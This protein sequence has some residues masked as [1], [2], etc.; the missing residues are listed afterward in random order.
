LGHL[1]RYYGLYSSRSKGKA[2]QE[3]SVAKFGYRPKITC[4]VK[5]E[6]SLGD[7]AEEVS[8]KARRKSR[9]RLIQKVYEV[10]PLACPRYSHKMPKVL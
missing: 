4:N 2:N 9:A 6:H 5:P 10:D 8:N 1:I 3:G 7:Y